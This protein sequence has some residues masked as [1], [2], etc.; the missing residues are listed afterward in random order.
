TRDHNSRWNMSQTDGRVCGVD[1]LTAISGSTENIKLTVVHIQMKVDLFCL[2]HDCHSY[3]GSMDTSAGLRLRNT[4]NPVHTA[5][6]FQTGI[7]ALPLNHE[8]YF[9]E[10]ADS[11]LIQTHHLRLPSAALR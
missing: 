11:I 3:C 6:I 10:T 8:S 7:S 4:L 9:F 1:T 2:R 5:F